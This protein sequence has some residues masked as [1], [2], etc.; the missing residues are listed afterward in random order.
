MFAIVFILAVFFA[1]ITKHF[2]FDFLLQTKYQWS[3]KGKYGHPGGL[4]HAFL[5]GFGTFISVLLVSYAMSDLTISEI[6]YSA[7]LV[8]LAYICILEMII[9][10]HIDWAKIKLNDKFSLTPEGPKFWW[11]LGFDQY[12]HYLTYILIV[13]LLI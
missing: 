4:L 1:L 6:L 9:H 8:G 13:C 11:L 2:I 7:P 12:L 10:Y 3:N 5:A